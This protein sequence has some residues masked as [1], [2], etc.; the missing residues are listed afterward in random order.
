[1]V[2]TEGIYHIIMYP[3]FI[4]AITHGYRCFISLIIFFVKHFISFIKQLFK[5]EPSIKM[6]VLYGPEDVRLTGVSLHIHINNV[7]FDRHAWLSMSG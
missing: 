3:C 4:T 2:S 7:C 6:D 1:M 5:P